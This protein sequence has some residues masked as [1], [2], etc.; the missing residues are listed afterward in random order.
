MLRDLLSAYPTSNNL[1]IIPTTR[2]INTHLALSSRNVYLSD[3]ERK[4]APV[5]FQALSAARELTRDGSRD[6]A[7]KE[8]VDMARDFISE[9]AREA[10]KEGVGI[11]LDYIEVFDK[12]SFAS[13]GGEVD[14]NGEGRKMID[15]EGKL[16]ESVISGAMWVGKTRLIDNLLIGWDC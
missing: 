14:G 6:V 2:D 1:H 8:L 9:R 12:S 16:R 15:R 4:Y 7:G 10:S 3:T 11:R 13:L 5:L